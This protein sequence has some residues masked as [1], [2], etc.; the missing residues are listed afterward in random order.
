MADLP[1]T[2]C[3]RVSERMKQWLLE[4]AADNHRPIGEVVRMLMEEVYE[5][6]ERE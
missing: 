1:Y 6:E 5:R 2:V 3:F 4:L